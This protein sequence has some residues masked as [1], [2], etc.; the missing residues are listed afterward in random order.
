MNQTSAGIGGL[1]RGA[2][3]GDRPAA[4]GGQKAAKAVTIKNIK[5]KNVKI[6]I[7]GK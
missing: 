5:A 3:S 2:L 1:Q 4:S 7:K 6:K